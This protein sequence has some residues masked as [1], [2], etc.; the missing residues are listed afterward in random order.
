MN[1][2]KFARSLGI[3]SK[4]I[5]EGDEHL[6]GYIQVTELVSVSVPTF[7]RRV[8]VSLQS[9]DAEEFTFYP[10]RSASDIAGI[11]SDIRQACGYVA[12]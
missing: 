6:D 7:G 3:D 12:A 5:T 9:A 1:A 4:N 10:E 2:H 8:Y 11:L